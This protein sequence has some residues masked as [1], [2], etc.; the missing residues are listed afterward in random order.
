[1]EIDNPNPQSRDL[2]TSKE[3][4]YQVICEFHISENVNGGFCERSWSSYTCHNVGAIL[5]EQEV[6]KHLLGNSTFD[7]GCWEEELNLSSWLFR[8]YL[9]EFLLEEDALRSGV[10]V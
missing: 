9:F 7:T 3:F 5:L 1:M 2:I 4:D 10:G 8:G 6:L